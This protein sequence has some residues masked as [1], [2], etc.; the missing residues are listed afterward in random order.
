MFLCVLFLIRGSWVRQLR[1]HIHT[2]VEARQHRAL[3]VQRLR[4]LPQDER[5]E[6]TADQTETQAGEC[7]CVCKR[8][9]SCVSVSVWE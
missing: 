5:T 8:M 3:P 9:R 4:A 7:V 2:A 1:G 6:Q